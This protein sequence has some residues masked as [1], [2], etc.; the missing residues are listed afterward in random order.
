MLLSISATTTAKMQHR[1]R[2][3][4]RPVVREETLESGA[5][6]KTTIT[7]LL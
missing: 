6:E 4:P 1:N 2:V 7:D 5:S 3:R